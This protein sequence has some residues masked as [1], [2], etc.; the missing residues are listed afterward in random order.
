MNPDW[1]ACVR[2]TVRSWRV[3]TLIDAFA[4]ARVCRFDPR[5]PGRRQAGA[6]PQPG[7]D[8]AHLAAEGPERRGARHHRLDGRPDLRDAARG[9]RQRHVP[10]PA[11]MRPRRGA[12]GRAPRRRQRL[13][14]GWRDGVWLQTFI[15]FIIRTTALATFM[16][17]HLAV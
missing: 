12:V 16:G 8:D 6:D 4:R 9:D 1:G 5:G 7:D 11:A 3:W 13:L 10:R 14:G 15:S 17:I 2:V